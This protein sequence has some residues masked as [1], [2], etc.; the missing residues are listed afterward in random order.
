MLDAGP[1][2]LEAARDYLPLF[3]FVL[4]DLAGVSLDSFSSAELQALASLVRLG[5]WASRSM[6][7]LRDALPLMR[8]IV[9]S[10]IR[11]EGTRALLAQLY[12]YLLRAAEPDVDAEQVRT[13]L[14][15]VAGPQ[16]REDVM[17]AGEQLIEQGRA[18]GLAEGR[19]E[20]RAEGFRAAVIEAVG[21]RGIALSD[22][23]R[24]RLGACRDVATLQRWH[25]RAVTAGSE[26][27]V[28]A[29]DAGE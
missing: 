7:R 20:G 1:E 22:R 23:G 16:G 6:K 24:A 9:A 10:L 11:D 21:A 29:E 5:F 17:N 19:A 2:L 26:D 8:E 15:E 18:E 12:V 27:E 25:V 3:R 13:M 14:F 28:F 4:D